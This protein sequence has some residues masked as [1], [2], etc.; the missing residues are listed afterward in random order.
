MLSWWRKLNS[1]V[2]PTLAKSNFVITSFDLWLSKGTHDIFAFLI[3]FLATKTCYTWSF[4]GC[5]YFWKISAKYLIELLEKYNEK[6]IIAYMKDE[7]FNVNT[8]IV[9]S[10]TIVNCE[11]LGLEKSYQGTCFRH[12]FSKAINMVQQIKNFIKIWHIF[13]FRL[14]TW[15]STL[16][17]KLSFFKRHYSL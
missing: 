11:I 9:V 16:L 13:L 14:H 15:R 4:W 1:C 7:G 17:A 5:K 10:K 8:M 2:L 6:K 3:N 12:A